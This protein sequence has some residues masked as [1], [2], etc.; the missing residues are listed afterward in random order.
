MPYRNQY[1]QIWRDAWDIH[2]QVADADFDDGRTNIVL[3]LST[4]LIETK[5]SEELENRPDM[6]FE[7]QT[8]EDIPKVPILEDVVKRHVWEKTYMDD[9]LF[10]SFFEK[11]LYGQSWI[12]PQYVKKKR[13]VKLRKLDDEKNLTWN[14]KEVCYQDDIYVKG[15]KNDEV[16]VE[17][18]PDLRKAGYCVLKDEYSSLDSFQDDF[19]DDIYKNIEFV[20]PGAWYYSKGGDISIT[21]QV[22]NALVNERIIVLLFYH[23]FKDEH[24]IYANG[25]EIFHGPLPYDHKELPLIQMIDRYRPDSLYHKGETELCSGLFAL[26][27]AV[28]NTSIDALKYAIS[29]MLVIPPGSNFNEDEI[30][31]RPGLVVKANL[32][33]FQQLKLGQ[34]PPE[35][36]EIRETLLDMIS[37]STGVNIRQLLGEPTSTTATVAALRKEAL[38]RRINLNLRLNEGRGFKRLGEQLISLVQ[39][40]YSVPRIESISDEMQLIAGDE[41]RKEQMQDG[42]V[43]N[44]YRTV[45]VR[46]KK[47]KEEKGENGKYGLEVEETEPDEYGFFESRPEYILT[48]KKVEVVVRQGSTVAVSQVLDQR[49][50]EKAID[51]ALKINPELKQRGDDELNLVYFTQMWIDS[52]KYDKE[53]AFGREMNEEDSVQDIMSKMDI[54]KF[55]GT[56]TM[57]A[58]QSPDGGGLPVPAPTGA[59]AGVGAGAPPPVLPDQQSGASVIGNEAGEAFGV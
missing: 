42:E 15:Y 8:D 9:V 5:L 14:E 56:M 4:M 10:E 29:P 16:W 37:W 20:K 38:S 34:I 36:T 57:G 3:P 52:L 55:A 7:G 2:D 31:A 32:G 59:P 53:K 30:V 35:A 27:N 6:Y 21:K 54:D 26:L 50:S 58:G 25:V 41:E 17:P 28:F 19:S 46:G 39:Q 49:K 12:S 22:R 23:K 18:V 44:Q 11:D 51:L 43:A 45:K 1:E 47:F 40:Y 13:W 24:V 48:K 33:N